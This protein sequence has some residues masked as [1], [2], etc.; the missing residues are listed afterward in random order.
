MTIIHSSIRLSMKPLVWI[1]VWVLVSA[2]NGGLKPEWNSIYAYIDSEYPAVQQMSVAEAAHLKKDSVLFL[3]VRDREEYVLSHLPGA[4]WYQSS[5]DFTDDSLKGKVV[6]LYC[7]VGV[8]SSKLADDLPD[9]VKMRVYNLKGSIFKWVAEG[10]SVVR[11]GELT[12]RVHPYND[13]WGQ[14]L[15][16]LYHPE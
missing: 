14:L 12:N 9:E 16:S 4:L 6:V 11:R 7:S 15:D 13:K 2:C 10:H 5:F 3:D 1:A 8:R